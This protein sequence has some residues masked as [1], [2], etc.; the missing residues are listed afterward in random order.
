MNAEQVRAHAK[1]TPVSN[2]FKN[3]QE[4]AAECLTHLR[5]GGDSLEQFKKSP[6]YAVTNWLDQM[7]IDLGAGGAN[8]MHRNEN[9]LAVPNDTHGK[10]DK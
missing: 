8:K 9:G 7:D 3:P 1:V 10:K 6:L 2:Y 5:M 4:M